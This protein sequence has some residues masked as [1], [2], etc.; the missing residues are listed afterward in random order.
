SWHESRANGLEL[1][2]PTNPHSG[3]YSAYL[4]GC[5]DCNDQIWQTITLPASFTS[6]T[7]SYW[8][9]IDTNEILTTIC[10]DNFVARLRTGSGAIIATVQTQCNLNVHGWTRYTFTVTSQLSAYKGKAIQISFQGTSDFF[11][12]TDFFV[13]DISLVVA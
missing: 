5:D 8:L 2:D 11:L 6:V 13:D 3:T 12:A 1:V 10:Y 4:C 7:F 9:Y